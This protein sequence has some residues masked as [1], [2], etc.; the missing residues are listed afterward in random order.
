MVAKKLQHHM[1]NPNIL[2]RKKSIPRASS[3]PPNIMELALMVD[4]AVRA[5]ADT[6][7]VV[8]PYFGYGRQDRKDQPRGHAT[9][10]NNPNWLASPYHIC[11]AGSLVLS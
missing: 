9:R 4:A 6:V 5:S 8:M 1:M 2:I 11:H 10:Q 3:P 7:T